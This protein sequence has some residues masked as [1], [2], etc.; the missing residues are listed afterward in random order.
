[1]N[2]LPGRAVFLD[3]DGVINY[4]APEGDYIKTWVELQF[5]P[6]ALQAVASLNL[7]GY[8]VFVVTNQRGV[9]TSRIRM[10]DLLEIHRRIQH[11]FA[12][13]G[14]TISQIY[15]CPHDTSMKC[16]CR[17]PQPG[18][19]LRAAREYKLRLEASWM[20]GDSVSDVVAGC[21]AGCRTALLGRVDPR[22]TSLSKP[23]IVAEDLE[24]AVRQILKLDDAACGKLRMR[25]TSLSQKSVP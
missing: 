7:A 5:I 2:S 20:I 11:E 6:G 8:W 3:R 23:T 13:S 4:K 24:S 9:A 14:A 1:M 22:A 17:K 18:M 25:Y 10:D 21:N 15:F 12:G 19:L 16:S